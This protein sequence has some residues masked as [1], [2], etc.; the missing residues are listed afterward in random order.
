MKTTA[1]LIE[2]GSPALYYCPDGQWCSN[3]N[4]ANQFPTKE[5]AEDMAKDMKTMEPVRIVEHM[6]V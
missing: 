4:H 2:C 5:G 1:W 6:W 3:A